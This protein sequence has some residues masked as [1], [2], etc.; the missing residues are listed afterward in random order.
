MSLRSMTG[1]GRASHEQNGFS[2]EI[3]LKGINSRFS[4]YNFK[5]PQILSP[6]E[7]DLRAMLQHKISRGKVVLTV[8]GNFEL[9]SRTKLYCDKNILQNYLSLCRSLG[10]P[11][12]GPDGTDAKREALK[13]PG[14]LKVGGIEEISLR[15]K[16]LLA[17]ML[18][19]GLD[20]FLQ[21]KIREGHKI[22]KELLKYA[23][24][25]NT[26]SHKMAARSGQI[27]NECEKHI[28]Q[29]ADRYCHDTSSLRDRIGFEIA[30][31]LDRLDVSE[32][33]ARLRF[34]ISEFEKAVSS[35]A[36]AVGR[37]LDFLLQEMHREV[38]TVGAKGRDE[39]L[40][41]WVVEA[42]DYVE[43]MRE[44]VQNVE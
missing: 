20:A 10:L 9:L 35:T 33:C 38:N 6:L 40:S 30:A 16:R 39:A 11:I 15:G 41:R 13:V 36:T 3:L 25:V 42:K 32:E 37:K 23:R 26:L 4:E 19:R 14:V 44:Q 31:S 5:L 7:Q 27:K 29:L 24:R 28:H 34:H 12:S 2:F 22:Q 17:K 18:R 21:S 1:F 8:N 43:R